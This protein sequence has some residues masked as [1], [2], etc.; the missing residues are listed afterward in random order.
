VGLRLKT[1]VNLSVFGNERRTATFQRGG[2]RLSCHSRHRGMENLMPSQIVMDATGDTRHQFDMNDGAEVAEAKR[3]FEELTE[4]GFIAAK[5]TDGGTSV[6][7]PK[8]PCLYRG[9]LA[10]DLSRLL[11]PSHCFGFRVDAGAADRSR[12]V[13]AHPR[14]ATGGTA[15]HRAPPSLADA[16]AGR[17]VGDPWRI[18]SLSM[19]LDGICPIV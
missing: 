14:A 13:V 12:P 5:R 17:A 11:Y 6:R 8:R 4:A 15:G 7:M 9:L 16:G 18:L 19:I 2:S 3:R 10:D 1:S